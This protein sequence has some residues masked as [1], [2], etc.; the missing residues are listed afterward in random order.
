MKKYLIGLLYVLFAAGCSSDGDD[1]EN[2]PTGNYVA[3]TG[4]LVVSAELSDG[5]CWR[6]TA[7]SGGAVFCQLRG[8]D[9]ATT[10]DYPNYTYSGNG[11]TMVCSFATPDKFTANVSGVLPKNAGNN[12][13][14]SSDGVTLMG[15]M[16][17]SRYDGVLDANGDGVI[18]SYNK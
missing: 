6:V 9:I 7:F 1:K 4:A 12:P 16:Q 2:A 17:F 13:G 15:P 18:D 11:F 10:G 5:E 14:V 8:M 3:S